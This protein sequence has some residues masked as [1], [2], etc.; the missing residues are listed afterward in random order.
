MK[1]KKFGKLLVLERAGSDKQ[2]RALWKCQCD[3]GNITIVRGTYLRS[4][5]TI[6]CGCEKVLSRGQK[7]TPMIGE[8]FGKLTV[9][10]RVEDYISPQGQKQPK[11]CCKCDCGNIVNVV[12]QSLRNNATQSCGCITTS[13]G[14]NN[15]QKIL[16]NNK[17]DFIKEYKFPDLGLL[18]YDFYLP[19]YNRLIEFDG[20]QH[21][22]PSSLWDNEESFKIR[23]QKDIIKNQ[24]AETHNIDLVRI[25]YYERDNITLDL[26]LGDKYLL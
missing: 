18:R 12:A 10:S 4:G 23:Q 19:K 7:I 26:L 16:I 20:K 25:P 5:H 15:I 22:T 2:R 3:C 11:Y 8:K 9:L 24:Y 14:E 21:Q 1:N 17:I 13:I 6:S